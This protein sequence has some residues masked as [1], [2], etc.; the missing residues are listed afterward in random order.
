MFFG[1]TESLIYIVFSIAVLIWYRRHCDTEIWKKRIFI[2]IISLCIACLSYGAFIYF[3][4]KPL[5]DAI[6]NNEYKKF[7][8]IIDKKYGLIYSKSFFGDSLLH[9][10]VNNN[11]VNI[12]K[13]LIDKALDVNT[14]GANNATP[15]HLAAKTGNVEIAN[16]LLKS[17]ADLSSK[18]YKPSLLPIHVAAVHGNLTLIKLFIC[19]GA[20]INATDGSGQSL[21]DIALMKK[22][23]NIVDFLKSIE[24]INLYVKQACPTI[25]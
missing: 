15:L 16:I 19:Y 8:N 23:Q 9:A 11:R 12:T 14:K 5:F 10:A 22:K 7:K 13:Y 24:D 2:I 18:A 3:E 17:G 20:D 6:E 25:K 1:K 21:I 4:Q